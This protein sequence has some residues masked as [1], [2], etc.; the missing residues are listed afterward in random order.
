MS[1]IK[2]LPKDIYYRALWYV[3]ALPRLYDEVDNALH[4]Q[5]KQ[6][7]PVRSTIPGR[8]VERI[9]SK[10][11]KKLKHI[12]T[13]EQAFRV[14]PVEYKDLVFNSILGNNIGITRDKQRT[15]A[16]YKRRVLIEVAYLTELI[17]EKDIKRILK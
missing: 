15:V 6:D 13:V 10:R 8:P 14:I 12:E 1:N 9:V 17:D 11:E 16:R 2:V 3:R 4:E 7:I 5:P